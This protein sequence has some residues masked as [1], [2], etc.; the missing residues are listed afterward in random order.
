[1]K[2]QERRI[3][4]DICVSVCVSVHV[5][6]SVYVYVCVCGKGGLRE[7]DADSKLKHRGLLD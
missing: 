3:L 5:C 1:M 7:F 2:P 4:T 6:V